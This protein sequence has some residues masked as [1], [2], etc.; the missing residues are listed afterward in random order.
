MLTTPALVVHIVS[1]HHEYLRR[2]LPLV[3]GWA[4]KLAAVHGAKEPKL[5]ALNDA[6]RELAQSLLEH[7]DQEE[8][9]VF[10]VLTAESLA[11]DEAARAVE[12]MGSDHLTVA[13]LLE[14]IRDY[15]N[16]FRAP[17]GACNTHQTLF[18][19]LREI[20]TD[21]LTHIHLENHVLAPRF[22]PASA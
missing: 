11:D 20:E 7:L 16:D 10:P 22:A 12:S 8:R 1:I 4:V 14:R 3:T 5:H 17:Q 6:V 18:A 19:E 15:T 9:T 2:A 21:V 13:K